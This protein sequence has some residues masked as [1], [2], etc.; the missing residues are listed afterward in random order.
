MPTGLPLLT[1]P[2]LCLPYSLVPPGCFHTAN[3]GFSHRAS[4]N[5]L[6]ESDLQARVLVPDTCWHLHMVAHCTDCL[7]R[8]VSILTA[9]LHFSRVPPPSWS[10]SVLVGE[11][12]RMQQLFLFP[13]PS[14]GAG[15]IL[16]PFASFF[17]LLSYL[18]L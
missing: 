9:S 10:I 2:Q 16:L 6:F 13:A 8:I 4:P 12:P 14:R 18:V 7:W 11:L 15:L 17:F 5:S 3:P 1:C